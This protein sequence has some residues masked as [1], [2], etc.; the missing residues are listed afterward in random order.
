[1]TWA[2]RRDD[3]EIANGVGRSRQ[4]YRDVI[5]LA[6]EHKATSTDTVEELTGIFS[7][8]QGCT[9]FRRDDTPSP[10]PFSIYRIFSNLK[11]GE[12]AYTPQE[13][14]QPCNPFNRQNIY[15]PRERKNPFKWTSSC[16]YRRRTYRKG[17]ENL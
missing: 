3:A 7:G 8:L 1:M 12:G 13:T 10:S 6:R 4:G 14:L 16:D 9:G 17:T 2:T 11:R 15:G 5:V